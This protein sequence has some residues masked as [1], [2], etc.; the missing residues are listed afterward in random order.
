MLTSFFSKSKPVNTILVFFYMTVGYIAANISLNKDGFNGGQIPKMIGVWV[1]YIFTVFTLDFISQKNE[2]TR[3][4][5]YRTLLF[6]SFTL[7]FPEALVSPE[8]IGSG[9]FIMLAMRRILSL[10]SGRK[11]ER[12]LFDAGLWIG[13]ATLTFFWSHVMGIVLVAALFFYG[14]S[15]GRYWFIPFLAIAALAI[16]TTCYVLFIEEGSSYIL[17]IIEDVSFDFG[18]YSGLKL[19]LPIAFICAFFLWTIWTFLKES[20]ASSMALRPTYILILVFAI[21]AVVIVVIAQDKNGAEWYFFAIPM[22][23]IGTSFFENA[24]SKWIPEVLLWIIVLLPFV[25]YFL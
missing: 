3:R 13:L 10:R 4:T 14:K 5:S 19:L 20:A 25:H 12:K 24:E 15:S 11:M 9:V 17:D 16:L 7:V 21:M 1:L 18:A 2:L 6:A 22:A 8:I 23:I